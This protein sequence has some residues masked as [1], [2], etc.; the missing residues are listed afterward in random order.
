[1]AIS[2]QL[3]RAR[4]AGRQ[5]EYAEGGRL[6]AEGLQLA[7]QASSRLLVARALIEL[8]CLARGEGELPSATERLGEAFSLLEGTPW[9]MDAAQCAR[10]LGQVA[11]ASGDE[12][13]ERRWRQEART[14]DPE[15][16]TEPW[17]N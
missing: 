14:L 3:A 13:E 5:G 17:T 6:A 16:V 15:G 8:G 9:W 11:K 1:M 4:I 7:K 2:A 10:L 12:E